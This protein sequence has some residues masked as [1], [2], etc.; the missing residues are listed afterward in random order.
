MFN[1]S[2]NP[3]VSFLIDRPNSCIR[4][5]TSRSIASG[6]ELFIFYGH[7]VQFDP[8]TGIRSTIQL[9]G[10]SDEEGVLRLG[11]N[12]IFG[13]VE[14]DMEVL[15]KRLKE[16]KGKG[17]SLRSNHLSHPDS[18]TQTDELK[19]IEAAE[20]LEEEFL[21]LYDPIS[22]LP[23]RKITMIENEDAGVGEEEMK[24]MQHWVADV[25]KR[26]VGEVFK[27]VVSFLHQPSY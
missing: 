4:Y 19:R 11:G 1:H 22:E 17:P 6:E 21:R 8:V 18:S 12:E 20:K 9:Q 23:F 25:E 15:R 26:E 27:S 3:N 5:V 10:D 7:K 13:E 24:T 16:T 14:E 2:P